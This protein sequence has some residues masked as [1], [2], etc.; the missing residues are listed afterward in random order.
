MDPVKSTLADKLI[1]SSNKAQSAQPVDGLLTETSEERLREMVDAAESTEKEWFDRVGR[2]LN[3]A[4]EAVRD[5]KNV[6]KPVQTAL[7]E[8]MNAFS[9]ARSARKQR[10]NV[11]EKL[12]DAASNAGPHASTT[13]A[14]QAED[15]SIKLAKE[16]SSLRDEVGE[17]SKVV[18]ELVDKK[19]SDRGTSKEPI[20]Q[21]SQPGTWTEVVKRNK[22]AK[23]MPIGKSDD[24]ATARPRVRTRPSSILVTVGA[25][26]FP[27]LSKKIRGGVNHDIIGNSVVGMRQAKSGGLLI[28]VRGDQT[29]IEAV[30]AEVAKSAGPETEVRT[31]QQRALI[32]VR[33][34]DQWTSSKEVLDEVCRS[35]GVGQEAVKVIS[36]R[37]RFGD[38]QMALVSLPLSDSRG[39]VSSGRLLVGMVSCRVRM[40]EPK[41]RCFH[42]LAY[43]HT[44]KACDGPDRTE[45]CR[46]CGETG[47]KAASCSATDRMVSAFAR[48]QI[49]VKRWIISLRWSDGGPKHTQMICVLQINVGVCRAS[50]ELA[51]ATANAKE[52]DVLII[53]EEHRD[54]GED[55]GWFPDANG[56]AAIA[57]LSSISVDA[58]GQPTPGFRWL[59]IKGYRLYSCYISPNVTFLEFE[60]FLVGLE[61]SVRTATGPVV[62]SGD[63]NSKSP[64]WGSPR[65]DRRGRALADLIAALGLVVR[66]EGGQPTFVR[67]ASESHLDL[68]LATQAAIGSI[69]DWA[70]MEEET[71][72]LHRYIWF[73]ITT[74]R[75]QQREQAK[76]GWAY[77]KFDHQKLKDKMHSGAPSPPID[78]PS[79]CKQ[80]VKWLT[81][82]CDAC[83]PRV[84][85]KSKR[86]PAFWWN[87]DIAELRVSRQEG[88]TPA[89]ARRQ[90]KPEVPGKRKLTSSIG[91]HCR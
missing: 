48:V 66:N 24:R 44:S 39:L 43:G 6:A 88:R 29:Q 70:V 77:S 62:V 63:F 10:Q 84:S 82:A 9:Q 40:A 86:R 30:R 25:D 85:G 64:E 16:F 50:Q 5:A 46:R 38:S 2:R 32:E 69:T 11:A 42:C 60:A 31:L 91:K 53:C 54:R 61:A 74:T 23:P 45:C 21:E 83:M 36:L 19:P 65:E 73:N 47:H 12:Q 18:R 1:A 80:A 3:T 89:S 55:N 59:E 35:T 76:K 68:T 34:L 87:D 27:E 15:G 28:E 49:Y 37:K 58:I 22:K 20:I 7:A 75:G 72:S 52:A 17:L 33:D 90:A 78:A 8:A 4:L 71:L 51:L 14:V 41:V 56:R 57:V 81:E 13:G 79:M 67:G 26:E